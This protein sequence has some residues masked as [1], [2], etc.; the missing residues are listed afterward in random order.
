M[1]L[2]LC[3]HSYRNQPVPALA[4]VSF[5]LNG[6]TL[7]RSS[8]NQLVLNDPTKYISR[9]HAKV[10]CREGN[11]FY[12]DLGS[13]PSVIN[14]H[15]V[16]KGRE[17]LLAEG[18]RI[19]I[20]DYLLEV[21]MQAETIAAPLISP[22]PLNNP[23]LPLF[24]PPGVVDPT[25][26]LP[27]FET[28]EV[29]AAPVTPVGKFP[30]ELA[31]ARLLD[32]STHQDLVDPLGLNQFARIPSTT[33]TELGSH[34]LTPQATQSDHVS[35]ERVAF[36]PAPGTA[37]GMIPTDYDLLADVLSHASPSLGG[38]TRYETAPAS[39]P[40]S[41]QVTAATYDSEVMQA[42]LRGL[43]LP[44]LKLDRSAVQV[45]ESIGAML[46]EATAGTMDVLMARAL[47]KEE[48]ERMD[49]TMMAVR[50]N[51]PLKF[52]SNVDSALTQLLSD[53]TADYMPPVQAIA[54]AFD[55][56]RAHELS[57]IAG[58]RTALSAL[59]ERCNPAQ[60][61]QSTPPAS[62]FDKMNG[63]TAR[64]AKMWQKM[65]AVYAGVARDIQEA[66][67]LFGDRFSSADEEQIERLRKSSQ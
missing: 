33:L 52:F 28:I 65:L 50:S 34:A 18:D 60:I 31:G 38:E 10:S 67:E 19:V 1:L 5:S 56:L 16:G 40:L 45:A 32:M 22:L 4:P 30:D 47:T 39:Q 25:T 17:I 64:Q 20:G 46:R 43:G 42:L 27:L 21:Q 66:Q 57:V 12:E 53:S 41:P 63:G 3:T 58:M 24:E 11:W 62:L 51:N 6:G 36:V 29:V 44:D 48:E 59:L 13:N 9:L 61:E 15:P 55:D 2:T 26:P 54:G 35:P 49:M 7:G 23:D 8:E 14:D 37:A